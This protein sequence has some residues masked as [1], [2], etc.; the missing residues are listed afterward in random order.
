[1]ADQD[2]PGRVVAV[3][4]YH[5]VM[6]FKTPLQLN[7]HVKYRDNMLLLNFNFK[8]STPWTIKKEPIY[9]ST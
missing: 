5:C 1:M 7:M 9:F 3:C 4:L 6:I 2:S 8:C